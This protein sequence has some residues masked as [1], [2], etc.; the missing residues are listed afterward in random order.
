M[1]QQ[2]YNDVTWASRRPK[3]TAVRLYVQQ[4]VQPHCNKI[5]KL[6]ITG[7]LWG[8]STGF[9][10]PSQGTSN[11]EYV[12]ILSHH[13]EL[14]IRLTDSRLASSQWETLQ[15]NV[16]SHCLGAN[17]ESALY[18]MIQYSAWPGQIYVDQQNQRNK[19]TNWIMQFVQNNSCNQIP[20]PSYSYWIHAT[21]VPFIHDC[22]FGTGTNTVKPPT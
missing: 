9:E 16:V 12:S 13:R 21:N 11:A 8:E 1:P 19:R 2:H 15:S 5:T 20:T 4:L 14:S 18:T 6:R 3:S 22:F 7:P 10:S 17:L